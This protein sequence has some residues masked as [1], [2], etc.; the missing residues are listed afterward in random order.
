LSVSISNVEDVKAFLSVTKVEYSIKGESAT[1]EITLTITYPRPPGSYYTEIKK[2]EVEIKES[3]DEIKK[4]NEKIDEKR[5]EINIALDKIKEKISSL[6]ELRDSV[7]VQLSEIVNPLF[8]MAK[9]GLI[10]E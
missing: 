4:L 1:V 9:K 6:L 2:F 10:K 7:N 8:E 5:V 3:P